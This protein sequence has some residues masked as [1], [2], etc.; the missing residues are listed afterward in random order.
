MFGIRL[1]ADPSHHA[2]AP[3]EAD[4]PTRRP[5]AQAPASRRT[6]QPV[7]GFAAKWLMPAV[8]ATMALTGRPAHGNDSGPISWHRS[9]EQATTAAAERNR[10]VLVLFTAAWSPAS[11]QLR[12]HVLTD[13]DAVALLNACFEPV[14]IDVD[15]DPETTN[16]LGIRHVPG[17]CILAADGSVVS[18]FECPSST[19][20]FIATVAVSTH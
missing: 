20:M 13:P 18:R 4:Q 6:S 10:Q 14:I 3:A 5:P 2:P 16:S 12:K 8:L 9:L 7:V 17:G 1:K 15:D 11:T 19:G